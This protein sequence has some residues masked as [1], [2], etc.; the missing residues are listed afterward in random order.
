MFFLQRE[1]NLLFIEHAYVYL[2]YMKLKQ[3]FICCYLALFVTK[4]PKLKLI[5]GYNCQQ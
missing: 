1:G 4:K 2:K 3:V 5:F